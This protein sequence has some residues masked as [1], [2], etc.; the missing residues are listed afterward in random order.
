MSNIIHIILY[1]LLLTSQHL[2]SYTKR[3][4][5]LDLSTYLFSFSLKFASLKV[6]IQAY[7]NAHLGKEF[8]MCDFKSTPD[9][10]V[11]QPKCCSLHVA[12]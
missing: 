6:N 5:F 2:V 3:L 8:R 12:T 11:V 7:C 1:T 9:C 4:Y 10:T